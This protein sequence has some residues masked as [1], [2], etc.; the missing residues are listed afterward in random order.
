MAASKRKTPAN[1][2]TSLR[3]VWLAGLGLA[4]VARRQALLTGDRVA[5]QAIELKRHAL[6]VADEARAN[7]VGGLDSVR[8]QVE[9]RVVQFSTQVE[10]RLAPVLDKL[11]LKG[12]AHQRPTRKARKTTAS[13]R[14]GRAPAAKQAPRRSARRA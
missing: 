14:T 8:G 1:R 4:V 5:G 12:T 10:A 3:H 6:A 13:K 7:V 9:S 11:G 2:E